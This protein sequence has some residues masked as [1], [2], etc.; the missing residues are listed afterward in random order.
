M[1]QVFTKIQLFLAVLCQFNF[2]L[3]IGSLEHELHIAI[4]HEQMM[5]VLYILSTIIP[6]YRT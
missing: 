1:S 4:D 3:H 2:I 6:T 5:L